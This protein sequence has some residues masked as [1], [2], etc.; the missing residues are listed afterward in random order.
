MD[1]I[2]QPMATVCAVSKQG[3]AEGDK[4]VSWLVRPTT[5]DVVRYDVLAAHAAGFAPVGAIICR[6]AH[7]YKG[8]RSENGGDRALKLTT[9][10]LFLTLVD[11]L[12]EPTP[13]NTRLVQF[14][15]LMLERKKILKPRGQ[16]ADKEK[17]IYEHSKSKQ[18]FEIPAGELTMEF[19][20]AVQEQ[21][22]VLVGEPK[23]KAAAA[24]DAAKAD[25]AA[26]A[27]EVASS[28][29][30]ETSTSAP[31]ESAADVSPPTP[32]PASS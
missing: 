17:N 12:T 19:F 8:R 31:T 16:T 5:V 3:F 32:P 24:A 6:W 10:N 21:L 11:P 14:L 22:S 25:A 23:K 18:L 1:L 28:A 20:I 30:T 26:K 4:V 29:V 27:G 15:T 9:E 13:E 7:I 2:L